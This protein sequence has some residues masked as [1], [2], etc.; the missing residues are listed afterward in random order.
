MAL[1]LGLTAVCVLGSSLIAVFLSHRGKAD[2]L[3]AV[4]LGASSVLAFGVGVL[5]ALGVS[6]RAFRSDEENGIRALLRARG[7]SATS[8][9]A[10]RIA[11]LAAVLAVLVAGGS[12]LVGLVATL[13]ARGRVPALHTAQATL[14]AIVFGVAFALTFAPVAMATLAARS[15]RGGYVALLMVLLA[16]ELL[17]PSLDRFV[18]HGWLEVCS[19]PGALLAVRASL[20]P[21]GADPVM[22]AHGA[23]ALAAIC[24]GALVV[25]RVELARRYRLPRASQLSELQPGRSR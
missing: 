22:L 7:V 3:P 13:M 25:V 1:A 24:V 21:A 10:G 20:A 18:P 9:L 19:I 16:P 6:T 17:A 4:P 2:A 14:A 8:Y 23:V 11:G 12:A 15:R 5:V